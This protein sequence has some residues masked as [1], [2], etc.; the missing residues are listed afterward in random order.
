MDDYCI[1]ARKKVEKSM[2]RIGRSFNNA[3]YFISQSTKDAIREEENETG[4]FGVAFAFDEENERS[5]ILKWMNMEDTKENQEVL[6]SMYQGQ[7]LMKDMYGRS[8]KITVENLFEEWDG[9]L[10]TVNKS[11]VA[12]AEEKYL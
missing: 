6:E 7:C 1:P 4:N 11:E 9:A 5:D 10:E 3:L 8:G 12:Y 2:K